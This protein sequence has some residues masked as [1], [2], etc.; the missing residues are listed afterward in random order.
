M[1]GEARKALS[2]AVLQA[3]EQKLTEEQSEGASMSMDE[4]KKQP[5]TQAM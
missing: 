2:D 4:S 1:S 5:I 3:Y